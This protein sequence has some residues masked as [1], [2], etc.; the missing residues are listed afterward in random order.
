[1][2]K[3]N[4]CVR[5]WTSQMKE[6]RKFTEEEGAVKVKEGNSFPFAFVQLPRGSPFISLPLTCFSLPQIRDFLV[7]FLPLCS[8]PIIWYLFG[9][10]RNTRQLSFYRKSGC[11]TVSVLLMLPAG[12]SFY[13]PNCPFCS[14]LALFPFLLSS[15][16]YMWSN[17]R[18]WSPEFSKITPG[19]RSFL[20]FVLLFFSAAL[21]LWI[22]SQRQAVLSGANLPRC[23]DS[24]VW[25][26]RH[27]KF[28]DSTS[29]TLLYLLQL[30]LSALYISMY[31]M[32]GNTAAEIVLIS[33][34][35]QKLLCIFNPS[36]HNHILKEVQ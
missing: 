3:K 7:V 18:H 21:L 33:H 23:Y 24:P 13:F 8:V 16:A 17:Y 20:S 28:S 5:R 11:V 35:W 14:F 26:D 34:L 31:I 2:G 25:H 30:Y 29:M 27:K 19:A 32:L 9:I 6:E 10:Q 1:M 12:V 15:P 22:R 36:L 4:C